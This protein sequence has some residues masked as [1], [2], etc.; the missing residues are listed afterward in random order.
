MNNGQVQIDPEDLKAARHPN[1]DAIEQREIE[2]KD[3][4]WED[5]NPLG[6]NSG[7]AVD[8]VVDK[9][10]DKLQRIAKVQNV[11]NNLNSFAYFK[12]EQKAIERAKS[13]IILPRGGLSSVN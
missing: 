1:M 3:N 11:R 10:H 5:M 7:D 8:E 9:L 4:L 12:A 2:L 6:L 13:G